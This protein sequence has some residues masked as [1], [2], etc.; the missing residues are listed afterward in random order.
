MATTPVIPTTITVHLGRPNQNAENIT[1]PFTDYIKNVA[2]SE[3]YP[4]WPEAAIRANILAQ[5]SF[6]LNRV[7]T[8]FYRSRGYD[9]DITNTTA[10]DQAYTK[11]GEVYENISRITDEIFNNYLVRTGS[12]E[13]LFA[14][15]CDGYNTTCPGLSQW[16]TV[17]L[18]NNGMSPLEILRFYFG[19]NVSIVFNAPISDNTQSYPGVALRRGSFGDDVVIIKRELNRIAQN[20]PAIPKI[21]FTN[22]VFDLE[23]ENAVKKF[24]EIFSLDP[25]GIVGKATWYKIKQIFASVKQLSDLTSEGLTISEISRRYTRE[26]RPGSQ[27]LDVE[28]LQYYLAFI[29]YFYPYLPPIPITGYFG[30]MTR[31][32]VF[33]FQSYYGLPVTG[34]VDGN[35]FAKV[36]QVYRDA[37]S[38]LPANYQS[39]IG[40]PYPG[41]FL[42]EGDRGESVRIIQ[43]YLNK[44]GENVPEIPVIAVDGIFG[45]LTK[46]AVIAFQQYLGIEETGAI[47]PVEWAEIITLGNNL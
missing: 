25:D 13:P 17:A 1:I 6:A 37:V 30:E 44:I 40:E 11:D 47:G 41:R 2:S 33:A 27:G 39:A 28:A 34:V 7:Y 36:E 45:R 8:E 29:G 22:G 12:V 10:F 38:E 21:R 3:I 26:L 43:G 32:A 16:G 24:Q 9:F 31:D 42:T 20:Y 5:I 18:A 14:Q 19:D 15:F 35:V 46:G 4:T 23:T